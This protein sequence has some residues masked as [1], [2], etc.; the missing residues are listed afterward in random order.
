MTTRHT[1]VQTLVDFCLANH[2]DIQEVSGLP[3]FIL[4]Q[5]AYLLNVGMVCQAKINQCLNRRVCV[6]HGVVL[7]QLINGLVYKIERLG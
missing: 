3:D 1:P 2:P 7:S 6:C 4:G 5:A